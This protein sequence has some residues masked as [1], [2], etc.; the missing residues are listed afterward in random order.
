M[1]YGLKIK[2]CIFSVCV[3][4]VAHTFILRGYFMEEKI[5]FKEKTHKFLTVM[6]TILVVALIGAIGLCT[7]WFYN[8]LHGLDWMYEH[9][10]DELCV[11]TFEDA[12]LFEEKDYLAV[13]DKYS[14]FHEFIESEYAKLPEKEYHDQYID[15]DI[16]VFGSVEAARENFYDEYGT[17]LSDYVSDCMVVIAV[18]I[19]PFILLIL[20]KSQRSKF[21]VT[22]N[23]IKGKKGYKKFDIAFS[24]IKRITQ[25]GKRITI[26]T[27]NKNLELSSNKK[28]NEIYNYIKPFVIEE[29]VVNN[30]DSIKNILD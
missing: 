28:S 5:L 29:P 20:L 1:C 14:S 25:K 12:T 27:E 19:I 11:I 16:L 6:Q 3:T 18:S 24:D 15:C 10:H 4:L 21:I 9:K 22:E 13:K 17:P 2:V 30:V 7:L 23:T 8:N 26:Q